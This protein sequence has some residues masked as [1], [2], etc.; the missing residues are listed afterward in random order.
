VAELRD[1]KGASLRLAARH[2]G[3]APHAIDAVGAALGPALRFV[4]GDLRVGHAGL[5]MDPVAL[6][7][8]RVIVPDLA[9]SAAAWSAPHVVRP[10][11]RSPI[12]EAIGGAQSAL[13]EAVQIG[14]G[15]PRSD[16]KGRLGAA[17]AQLDG[18]GLASAAERMARLEQ[19]VGTT[20]ERCAAAWIEASLRLELARHVALGGSW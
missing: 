8:D 6:V 10:P 1:A 17:R 12:D 7:T 19:S 20:V 18:V 4:A 3:V 2:R 15:A 14:I 5:E 9:P 13:E 11:S 16:W